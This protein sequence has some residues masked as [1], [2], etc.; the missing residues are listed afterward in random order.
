MRKLLSFIL[1]LLTSGSFAQTLS[2]TV[3]DELSH[4][5]SFATVSNAKAQIGEYTDDAGKFS[6]DVSKLKESDEILFSHL[7]YLEVKM[8]VAKLSALK[9]PIRMKI[10]NYGL[11]EVVVG[12]GGAK[13]LLL[14]ALSRIKDNYPGEFTN[15]HILFKD[16]S[17]ING[18]RNHYSNF[19]FNMYIPSYLAKDS[20][21][22]Y[23]VDHHHEMYEKK[24]ALLKPQIRPTMFLKLM[25][26]E[27]L[28]DK[29]LLKEANFQMATSS[30]TIDGEEYDIIEFSRKP[31][32]EDPSIVTRGRIYF[33][34][35]AY[36]N[37]KDQGIRFID[38]HVF[39]EKSARYLLVAKMDSVNLNVKIAYVKVDGKYMLDYVSQ[40]AVGTGNIFGKHMD[41]LI[42]SSAKV[43]DRQPHL[44]MNEIVMKA[45]VDDIFTNEKP[46]D[47][48]EMKTPPDMR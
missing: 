48:K 44:K 45:E 1:L 43:I 22:I 33:V 28:F 2:G 21:R 29:D 39:N 34:G 41:V 30:T 37:K 13:E 5:L 26:P 3:L 9:E 19:D 18:D 36:I 42:N 16:Y 40:T 15:N 17:V 27:R 8:T 24:G 11:R 38:F 23:T 12:T 14:D 20:P 10:T 32:K 31:Q 7:G 46:K 4:P 47:I 35:H 25:Y 6:I